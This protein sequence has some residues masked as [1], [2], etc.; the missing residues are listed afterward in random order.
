MSSYNSTNINSFQRIVEWHRHLRIE[1]FFLDSTLYSLLI[2]AARGGAADLCYNMQNY[3]EEPVL[4]LWNPTISY[5]KQAPVPIPRGGK[6]PKAGS[7][8]YDHQ[9]E[10]FNMLW[11]TLEIFTL[12]KKHEEERL[13]IRWAISSRKTGTLYTEAVRYV[14]NRNETGGPKP[15]EK[16]HPTR[17]CKIPSRKVR[18]SM[19]QRLV[20][21]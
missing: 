1:H 6:R 8:D 16:K 9:D 13:S 4:Q 11:P 21:E 5:E 12:W 19:G 18:V 14:C 15:Y 3:A 20:S 17:V 10:M 7:F 2:W